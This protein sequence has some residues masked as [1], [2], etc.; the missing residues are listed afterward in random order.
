[1][2]LILR[3]AQHTMSYE[4]RIDRSQ[5]HLDKRVNL[6]MHVLV[7]TQIEQEFPFPYNIQG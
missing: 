4:N 1:M 3:K 2:V 7:S 5:P 6:V